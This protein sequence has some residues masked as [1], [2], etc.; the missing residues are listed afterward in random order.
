MT[1]NNI[2]EDE[3]V[4][5]GMR[6]ERKQGV[7]TS[8]SSELKILEDH[9]SQTLG[10]KIVESEDAIVFDRGRIDI[11]STNKVVIESLEE[12]FCGRLVHGTDFLERMTGEG[13][14]QCPSSMRCWE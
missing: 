8:Y 9:Y 6:V 5:I 12:E 13:Y 7:F 14:L 11:L 3:R 1:E 2:P 10:D 4:L